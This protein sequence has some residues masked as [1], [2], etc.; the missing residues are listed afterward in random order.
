MRCSGFVAGPELG[1][2]E[3]PHLFDGGTRHLAS[4]TPQHKRRS[5]RKPLVGTRR[6]A[7]VRH[8]WV[9]DHAPDRRRFDRPFMSK[10][11]ARSALAFAS[12]LYAAPSL[13]H[14]SQ[15]S[16]GLTWT[17]DAAVTIPLL[18]VLAAFAIGWIRLSARAEKGSALLRRRGMVFGVGWLVLAGALT[19][20]LHAGGERSFT[21][22]MIEHEL[23]MLVSAPLLVLARPL[24]IMLW[25]W[26]LHIRK[27]L[28]RWGVMA[29][30]SSAY[31]RSTDPV[32]ATL[33]QAAALLLWHAP[34]LFDL[35]LESRGW[36]AAQHLSFIL[37]SLLF[38]TAM[39]RGHNRLGATEGR[40]LA[41]LCLFATSV[42]SGGL[43]AL[44]ALSE[45][46]WYAGYAR[47][48]MAPLGLTPQEDQQ[49]AGLLMWVP[50]G[51]VH[52]LA[53]LILMRQILRAPPAEVA[54]DAG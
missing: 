2:C 27:K 45:S 16:G 5:A 13:A 22:H 41:V 19:S 9:G 49:F 44:M 4:R 42:V 28:G 21:L 48:G 38:W 54:F 50:G 36:H 20:P 10:L 34:T 8:I 33:L 37:A 25:A 43:G 3:H 26:P 53:A 12:V 52:A 30:L 14:G 29:P 11:A 31:R 17:W 39:L 46:P 6:V 51:L 47:L 23:L 32:V 15:T 1:R 24:V 35:S 7:R 18:L 40:A